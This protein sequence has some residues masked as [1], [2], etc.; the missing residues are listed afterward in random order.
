MSERWSIDE[1]VYGE[2]YHIVDEDGCQRFETNSRE[3]AIWGCL[4]PEL[5]AV[6]KVAGTIFSSSRLHDYAGL[7][8]ALDALEERRG[9]LE[10]EVSDG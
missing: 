1:I 2:E 3:D 6:A 7:K 10:E 9:E 8:I 4:L 5:E